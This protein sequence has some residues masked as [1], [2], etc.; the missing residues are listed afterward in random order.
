MAMGILVNVSHIWY[1]ST[2]LIIFSINLVISGVFLPVYLGMIPDFDPVPGA[3]KK[4]RFM[5]IDY[6]RCQTGNLMRNLEAD[7]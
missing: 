1:S 2:L 5:A 4:T 3:S 7:F 6:G